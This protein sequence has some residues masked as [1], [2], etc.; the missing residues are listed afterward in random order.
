MTGEVVEFSQWARKLKGDDYCRERAVRFRRTQLK[1]ENV[2][3]GERPPV[4]DTP[5]FGQKR[6]ED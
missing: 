2:L 3:W 5:G 4:W 6:E 1:S